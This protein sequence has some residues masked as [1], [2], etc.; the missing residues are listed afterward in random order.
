VKNKTKKFTTLVFNS[1]RHPYKVFNVILTELAKVFMKRK[2]LIMANLFSPKITKQSLQKQLNETQMKIRNDDESIFY[3][4]RVALI[5]PAFVGMVSDD[6]SEYDLIVRVGFT[7]KMSVFENDKNTCDISFLADW[8]ATHLVQNISKLKPDLEGI[9][10]FLRSDVKNIHRL[11]LSKHFKCLDFPITDVNKLFGRV[12][13]NFGVQ[14]I[15]FLLSVR[16]KKLYISNMD[17]NTSLTRPLEY[18]TNKKT[19]RNVKSLEHTKETI[20]NS[21]ID[22]HNPFTNF[23][24]FLTIQQYEKVTFSSELNELISNGVKGFRKKIKILFHN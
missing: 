16:P 22:H 10:F 18:A 23:S 7:G 20:K 1:L 8:H 13:P 9:I 12:T 15:Y 6:L 17:L 24:F 11:E 2:N 3:G 14:I 4:K 21:F 19:L 5:G